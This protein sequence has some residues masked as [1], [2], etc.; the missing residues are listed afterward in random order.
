[1]LGLAGGP[2][3]LSSLPAD[4]VCRGGWREV[5]SADRLSCARGAAFVAI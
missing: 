3:R 2:T 1:M 5:G 4:E